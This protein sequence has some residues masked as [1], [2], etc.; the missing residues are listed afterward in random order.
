MSQIVPCSLGLSPSGGLPPSGFAS[1]TG[2]ISTVR[3]RGPSS[4]G[5]SIL[6]WSLSPLWTRVG[7]VSHGGTLW[8][9][10]AWHN[11]PLAEQVFLAGGLS[12][13]VC[14]WY[15]SGCLLSSCGFTVRIG[16]D[17]IAGYHSGTPV[18][19]CSAAFASSDGGLSM[20]RTELCAKLL[21]QLFVCTIPLVV[22]GTSS[23]TPSASLYVYK[24]LVQ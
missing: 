24:P 1:S 16:T 21:T 7:C 14:F 18:L 3:P 9:S 5:T 15:I 6:G 23:A 17:W 10:H 22:G 19:Y 11:V 13:Y 8:V 2:D 12:C 20:D 4:R